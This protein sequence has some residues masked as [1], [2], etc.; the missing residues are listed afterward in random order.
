MVTFNFSSEVFDIKDLQIS[1]LPEGVEVK[2][3]QEGF[4][5]EGERP[6]YTE[7]LAIITS[8]TVTDAIL[9]NMITEL[10]KAGFSKLTG[11]A[12]SEPHIL[13]R[14]SHGGKKK[15]MY[16]KSESEIAQELIEIVMKGSVVKIEFRS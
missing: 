10:L 8:A 2:I 14:F 1:D 5:E 9:A 16:D 4:A 6:S 13:I 11:I 12:F 7:I 15:I 3:A